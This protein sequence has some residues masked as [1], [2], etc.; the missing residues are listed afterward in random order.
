M[1]IPLT[2]IIEHVCRLYP[3]L[4]NLKLS[5]VS[6][7]GHDHRSYRI[8]HRYV[9]RIPSQ[10][11]YASQVN[12]ECEVLPKIYSRLSLDIPRPLLLIEKGSHFPMNI[13]IY[14]WIDGDVLGTS[15][16]NTFELVEALSTF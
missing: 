15:R 3:E 2:Q 9:L 6:P 11:E 5:E 14:T 12:K 4:S 16:M 10:L 1:K 13:G 7:Q 8:G